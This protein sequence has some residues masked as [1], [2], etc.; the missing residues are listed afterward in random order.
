MPETAVLVHLLDIH[1]H[2]LLAKDLQAAHDGIPVA[3][4]ISRL[5]HTLARQRTWCADKNQRHTVN[6]YLVLGSTEQLAR[7]RT[8]DGLSSLLG[9]YC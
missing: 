2:G 8:N 6:D 5:T 4:T 9:V 3:I 1:G 7:M